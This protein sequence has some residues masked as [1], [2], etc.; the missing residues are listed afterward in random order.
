MLV[1]DKFEP[2]MAPVALIVLA[3]VT[4][5]V[6]VARPLTLRAPIVDEAVVVVA[7]VEVPVKVGALNTPRVFPVQLKFEPAVILVDG[8]S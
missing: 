3:A 5:P 4:A 1:P 2:V 6:N 8:V 7:K